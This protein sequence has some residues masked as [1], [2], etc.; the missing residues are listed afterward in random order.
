MKNILQIILVAFVFTSCANNS[1]KYIINGNIEGLNNQQII[2]A[3]VVNNS[4]VYIDT[5]DVL[6]NK[7]SYNADKLPENDFRFFIPMS[8]KNIFVKMYVDNSDI[9]LLGTIDSIDDVKIMGSESNDLYYGLMQEYKIIEK[10]SRDILIDKSIAE[11]D[12]EE[13]LAIKLDKKL[14]KSEN[15]KSDLFLNFAKNNKS[16]QLSVW[17]LFQILEFKDY[18]EIKPVFDNLNSDI[19]QTKLGQEFN[20]TITE[21]G[22]T[23]IGSS[24]PQFILPNLKGEKV[25]LSSFKNKYV[26]LEFWTP[27]CYYCRQENPNLVEIYSK[28]KNKGFEIVGINV[29]PDENLDIWELVIEQDKLAFPQLLDTDGVADKYKVSSTPYNVILDKNHKIIAKNLHGDELNAFLVKL[30]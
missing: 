11:M 10:E 27:M 4:P 2:Y 13:E 21:I 14:F 6:D 8:N 28:Y 9:T 12:E 19:K 22:K 29:E 17:A 1:N 7:F 30:F 15:R 24:A 5:V 20:A 26:M 3:K 18:K 23:A 25:S 16:S